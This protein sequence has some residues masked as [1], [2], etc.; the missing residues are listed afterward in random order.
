MK[1][2]GV[3]EGSPLVNI[4]NLGVSLFLFLQELLQNISLS[5]LAM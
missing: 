4:E 3:P 1:E 5:V 2:R